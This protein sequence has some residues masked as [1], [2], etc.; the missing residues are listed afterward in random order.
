[1]S[2]IINKVCNTREMISCY[3]CEKK[4]ALRFRT[5]KHLRYLEVQFSSNNEGKLIKKYLFIQ[6]E[7]FDLERRVSLINELETSRIVIS[8]VFNNR[9]FS[10]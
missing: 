6:D 4:Y 1:M 9:V 8:Q 5:S 7:E 2:K 10:I 3:I